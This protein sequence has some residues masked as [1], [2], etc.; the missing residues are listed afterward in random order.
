MIIQ[1]NPEEDGRKNYRDIYLKY[2]RWEDIPH[3]IKTEKGFLDLIWRAR[4]SKTI[5]GCEFCSTPYI[6]FKPMKLERTYRCKCQKTRKNPLKDTH[7]EYFKKSLEIPIHA[8]Y[9]MLTNKNGVATLAFFRR[10]KMNEKT[11]HLLTRRLS[12]WMDWYLKQ[13]KFGEDSIIE[14]DE[15]YPKHN[16]GLGEDY[17]W[18]SGKG[19]ER[20]HGVLVLCERDGFSL[21]I[22]YNKW[23]KKE[24]ETLINKHIRPGS[25]NTIYTDESNEYD[26]MDKPNSGYN[27]KKVN[28]KKHQW[29]EDGVNTNLAENLNSFIKNAL[30]FTHKGVYADYL[31]LYTSRYAFVHSMRSKTFMQC[32]DGLLS[33]LPALNEKVVS[34]YKHSKFKH[35][36]KNAA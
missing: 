33:V 26:F 32:I 22:P 17:P 23:K 5:G 2:G 18:S 21:A 8:L 30:K 9:E 29:S 31:Q 24:V 14:A 4:A 6:N 7:L 10:Y 35:I 34:N 11:A 28:H 13:Q 3:H 12:D 19:S 1:I 16:T 15:V 27:R 36:Y 25:K 20:T